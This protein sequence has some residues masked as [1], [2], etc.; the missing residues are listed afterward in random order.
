MAMGDKVLTTPTT[1]H[2]EKHTTVSVVEEGSKRPVLDTFRKV[3]YGPICKVDSKGSNRTPSIVVGLTRK[4]GKD[5]KMDEA[6]N[7]PIIVSEWVST[8]ATNLTKS[9]TVIEHGNA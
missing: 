8:L 9:G 1:L 6:N 4:S 7:K 2:V 5:R 3:M